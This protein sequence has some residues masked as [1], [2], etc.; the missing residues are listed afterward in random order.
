TYLG[1]V[2]YSIDQLPEFFRIISLA[3]PI[4]YM[5]NAFRY[6]FLGISDVPVG[7][8]F[9]VMGVLI[10]VLLGTVLYLFHKGSGLKN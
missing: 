4:L 2:F 10:V 6:G 1:G 8:S 7:T 9:A 5:V 3:N